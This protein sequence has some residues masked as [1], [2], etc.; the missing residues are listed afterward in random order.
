MARKA[1]IDEMSQKRINE[2]K[3]LHKDEE[4]SQE[5]KKKSRKNKRIVSLNELSPEASEYMHR[6][7]G[8][9]AQ[10]KRRNTTILAETMKM[11]L[12]MPLAEED[13]VRRILLSKGLDSELLTE[14]TAICFTQ[15]QRAKQDSKAFEVVR[16][17]IGQKPVERQ[18]VLTNEESPQR[19]LE[20]HFS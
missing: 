6:L 2:F 17:T 18:V 16:D 14:A 15:V 7:G 11:L 8:I 20:K 5:L 1:L 13:D 12:E 19:I 3:D 10:E 4:Y 9:A